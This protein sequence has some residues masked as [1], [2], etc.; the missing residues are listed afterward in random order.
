LPAVSFVAQT[1]AF[2]PEGCC[3]THIDAFCNSPFFFAHMVRKTAEARRRPAFPAES[4]QTIAAGGGFFRH[5]ALVNL[6]L[7]AYN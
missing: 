1:V 7:Q 3:K 6:I 2:R 4:D 5:F